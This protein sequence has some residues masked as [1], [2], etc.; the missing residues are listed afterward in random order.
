LNPERSGQT[1]GREAAPPSG[2]LRVLIV[3]EDPDSR[4]S[5]R[6]S[7]QRAELNIVAEAGF[8]TEAVVLAAETKPDAVLVAV[9]EPVG[10]P[11]ETAEAIANALPDTPI[12]I[13]SSISDGDAIRRAMVFG[14]RDYLVKP[15]QANAIRGAIFRAL[16]QE[17]R[18]Q[19][20]RAGQLAGVQSRGSVITVTGA[21]GGIGKSV[22]SVNLAVALRKQTGRNVVVLDADTQF[23]DIATMFD[24]TAGTRARQITSAFEGPDPRVIR[25]FAVTHSSGVQIL[26]LAEEDD[27]WSSLGAE[28]V[29]RVIDQLS[30]VYEFVVVDTAGSFDA[31]AKACIAASTLT[32]MVTSRDVSSVRDA[33]AAMRRAERWGLDTSRLR[34]VLNSASDSS[35]V[36]PEQVEKAIG[37]PIF[38]KLPHDRAVTRS[39]QLGRPLAETPERSTF[40]ASVTSLAL[41]I[42]GSKTAIAPAEKAEPAWRRLIQLRGKKNESPVGPAKELTDTQR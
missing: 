12:I 36:T 11:L 8:G 20:R 23:G 33:G 2:G 6:K 35:D 39:I 41:L 32:L 30:R 37:R 17:E 1:S 42:A 7:A 29:A 14:A 5:T 27:A 34:I 26:A 38:W 16:E 4:V 28:G 9:E 25:E 31:F 22:V 13:Y 40:A 21:K 18:R 24:L 15:V 10:R 19:M 3:D